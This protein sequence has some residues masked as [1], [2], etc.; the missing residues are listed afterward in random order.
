MHH[1]TSHHALARPPAGTHPR[2]AESWKL[3]VL[4]V[5]CLLSW[6]DDSGS[7]SVSCSLQLGFGC[8]GGGMGV[9]W[10]GMPCT[11]LRKAS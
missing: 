1:I 6:L 9:G 3:V 2:L 5:F 8:D 7:L 10:N 4:F 11:L